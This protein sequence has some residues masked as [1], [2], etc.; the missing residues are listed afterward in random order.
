MQVA[1]G[2]GRFY[3]GGNL[4]HA[5]A[6]I[7]DGILNVYSLEP[8][9]WWRLLIMARAFRAGEHH[10]LRAVRSTATRPRR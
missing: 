4:V 6:R 9:A 5:G 10:K 3:G 8:R 1:V 2:N 7:D